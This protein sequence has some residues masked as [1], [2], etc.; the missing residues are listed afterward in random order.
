MSHRIHPTVEA[1][2]VAPV[3]CVPVTLISAPWIR[4][5]STDRIPAPDRVP[6]PDACDRAA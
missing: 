4:L 2:E 6:I 1:E 5:V 3:A